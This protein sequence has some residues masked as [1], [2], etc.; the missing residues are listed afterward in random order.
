MST[1]ALWVISFDDGTSVEVRGSSKRNADNQACAKTGKAHREIR[2]R[3]VISGHPHNGKRS[4]SSHSGGG[5]P[6]ASS[7]SSHWGWGPRW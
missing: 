5:N 7:S 6:Y 4:R 3:G 2:S 1:K